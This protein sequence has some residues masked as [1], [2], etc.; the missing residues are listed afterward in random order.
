D[1]PQAAVEV[2]RQLVDDHER[3]IGPGQRLANTIGNLG[4]ALSRIGSTRESM[5]A[6]ERAAAMIEA[7]ADRDHYLYRLS[8]SNLAALHLREDEPEAAESLIRGILEDLE[9]RAQTEGGV[10]I[11]YLA[12]ALDIL[13]SSLSLQRRYVEAAAV[14][15]S[16]IDVL[17]PDEAGTRNELRRAIQGRLAEV[18]RRINS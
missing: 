13:G 3:L 5:A 17:I 4:V 10:E 16:A 2:Y 12:S 1:N 14:Y 8:I 18:E 15:Q 6:F 7:V 9:K 11:S